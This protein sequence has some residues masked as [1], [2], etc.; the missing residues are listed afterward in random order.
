MW[1]KHTNT[2]AHLSST[3]LF[4]AVLQDVGPVDAP[5]SL[6]PAAFHKPP[7]AQLTPI[8]A[9]VHAG[10]PICQSYCISNFPQ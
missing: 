6:P 8:T 10:E 1:I 3:W 9:D 4:A 2:S 7:R 5:P